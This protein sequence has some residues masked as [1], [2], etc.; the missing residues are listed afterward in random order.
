MLLGAAG[1]LM[2]DPIIP[3]PIIKLSIPG[4]H[5]TDITCTDG[6]FTTI[7]TIGQDGFSNENNP[8]FPNDKSFGIHNATGLDITELIFYLQTN[9]VFQPFTANTDDFTNVKISVN[10]DGDS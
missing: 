8:E 10:P 1:W 7:G 2:A 5:S 4:G 3:D 6:C 9:N